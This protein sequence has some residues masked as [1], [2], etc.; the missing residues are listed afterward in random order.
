MLSVFGT[1][2]KVVSHLHTIEV[3]GSWLIKGTKLLFH[4]NVGFLGL[5]S[6]MSHLGLN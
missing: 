5:S 4:S 1:V 2:F 6:L 3:A